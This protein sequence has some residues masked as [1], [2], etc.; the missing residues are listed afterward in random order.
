MIWEEVG[1]KWNWEN[2]VPESSRKGVNGCCQI[3]KEAAWWARDLPGK[4][5]RIPWTDCKSCLVSLSSPFSPI[6]S[7]KAFSRDAPSDGVAT[8]SSQSTLP[9]LSLS[10]IY[11]AVLLQG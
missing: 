11:N 8:Q 1:E 7:F 10:S 9:T 6:P 3:Q 4:A 5:S 2:S